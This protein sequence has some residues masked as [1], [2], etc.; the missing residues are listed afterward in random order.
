MKF[1]S[2]GEYCD[3]DEYI[4][5]FMVNKVLS[6]CHCLCVYMLQAHSEIRHYV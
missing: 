4:S 1:C 6:L 5:Y 2:A 3:L